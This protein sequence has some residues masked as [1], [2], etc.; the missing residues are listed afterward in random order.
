M[1]HLQGYLMTHKRTPEVA[2]EKVEEWV[3]KHLQNKGSHST[4]TTTTTTSSSTELLDV[5]RIESLDADEIK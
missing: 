2:A 1:A 3:N 5:N 4:T